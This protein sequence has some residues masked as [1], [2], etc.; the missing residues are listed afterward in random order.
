MPAVQFRKSSGSLPF[1]GL[2]AEG[3]PTEVGVPTFPARLFVQAGAL[4]VVHDGVTEYELVDVRDGSAHAIALTLARC[5]GLLSQAPMT[6]RP[7]PA[8]PIVPTEGAQLQK[9]IRAQYGVH[10][11]EGDPYALA[12]DLPQVAG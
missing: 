6:T 7:L 8:G 11:G 5:T 1:F 9:R 10:V 12:D 3:G 2:S 4:T